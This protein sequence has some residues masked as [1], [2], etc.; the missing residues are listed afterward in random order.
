LS[1]SPGAGW[2]PDARISEFNR[3]V[4]EEF[5]ANGGRV[6]GMFAGADLLLLTTLGA[7]TGL[8]H[9]VPLGY[10]RI[11]GRLL[12]VASAGGSPRH[13]DWYRNLLA[14]PL[15]EVEIGAER[16][17]AVAVPLEGAE[18]DEVFA[19]IVRRQPGY[20]DY[21][22]KTER[23]LPV[24]ALER[25]QSGGDAEVADMAAM[26]LR[27]HGW[28]RGQLEQ[29]RAQAEEYFAARA[30]HAGGGA[31]PPPPLGLRIRQHCLAFCQSLR[32]HHTG[33]D[34]Q[35][36]PRLEVE[37][38]ELAGVVARLRAEHAV[39]ARIRADLEA[40]PADIAVADPDRFR[41]DLDRMAADLEAHLAYEEE[42]M[43][44]LLAKVPFPP[45]A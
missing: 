13:P 27:V 6:G 43:I 44:P 8:P 37:Y 35:L 32:F 45:S 20:G 29:V 41:A 24:V 18:R 22:A 34:E 4:V 30:A 16:Y 19:E 38:P 40:L 26:L 36:L 10:L 1:S 3:P 23:V 5:R 14:R 17:A 39:V 9:T 28:L 31:P 21:Q 2:R 42:Q 11:G 15:V 12:V 25:A 33:E 7:R